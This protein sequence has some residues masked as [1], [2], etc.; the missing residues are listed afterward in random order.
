MVKNHKLLVCIL[1]PFVESVKE[2]LTIDL[3]TI[4]KGTVLRSNMHHGI[5]LFCQ[6]FGKVRFGQKLNDILG[7]LG[8]NQDFIHRIL[9]N[10]LEKIL[11]ITLPHILT[12]DRKAKLLGNHLRRNDITILNQLRSRNLSDDATVDLS[13][14]HT[15]LTNYI[16]VF[17]SCSEEIATLCLCTEILHGRK[18]V[19]LNTIVCLIKVDGIHLDF[20]P[21]KLLQRVIGGENQFVTRSVLGKPVNIRRFGRRIVMSLTTMNVHH[22]CIGDKLKILRRQL[23]CQKNTRS[24]HN[25]SLRSIRL[26][27][28]HR[29]KDTN[30][31]LTTA[32]RKHTDTFRMLLESIQGILLVG[33]EL[34]HR[35]HCV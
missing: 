2:H 19:P 24:N 27:L 22:S 34:N 18:E 11:T 20:C 3:I 1:A 13:I 15:C 32:G 31:G 7:S 28:L 12:L 21:L 14:V 9:L 5:T 26:E 33:T 35:S 17:R 16:T 23:L 10:N 8:T 30:V 4:N 29:I 25:N 6:L